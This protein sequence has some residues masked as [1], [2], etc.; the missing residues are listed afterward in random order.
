MSAIPNTT[1][2]IHLSLAVQSQWVMGI[3][4]GAQLVRIGQLH[5]L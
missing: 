1:R 4:S 3:D 5:G 2:I